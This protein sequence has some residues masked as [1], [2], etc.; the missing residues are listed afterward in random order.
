MITVCLL[1]GG[2]AAPQH[3][4]VFQTST[5]DAL[6]AGLYDGD[7]S[8]RHLL[9]KG[10]FGIG[11][12]DGLDGEM[13]LLDG[14]IYQVKADGKVYTPGSSCSTPF[15]TVC[16]FKADKAFAIT[17]PSDEKAV[18]NLINHAAPNQNLFYA[19]RIRGTFKSVKTR[20]VPRQQ[21][22]YPVL[23][24]VTR[25]QPEFIRDNVEGT[26]VGFRCPAFVKGVNVPGYHLH[27]ISHDRT[28]GGHVLGF[29]I[30][31]GEGDIDGLHQFFLRLPEH[32]ADFARTD[33]SKDRSEELNRVEK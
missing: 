9:E 29:E 3:N 1:V 16:R 24:A 15:A 12:F 20:S 5:I 21:K 26:I 30:T 31:A 25:H 6:L 14:R 8:C 4:V 11:T 2:C 18:E 27:F 19:I 33:L 28:F 7:L 13:V 17:T 22:P 32:A 10:D 23:E